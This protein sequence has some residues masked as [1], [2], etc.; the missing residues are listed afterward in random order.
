[1]KL[2]IADIHG[3]K[4]EE[5]FVICNLRRGR[6]TRNKIIAETSSTE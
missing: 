4:H 6:S 2:K 3:L 1:M 5:V